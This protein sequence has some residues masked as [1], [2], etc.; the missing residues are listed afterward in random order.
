MF[1]DLRSIQNCGKDRPFI[2][3]SQVYPQ[4]VSETRI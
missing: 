2:L 1:A 3:R 4:T